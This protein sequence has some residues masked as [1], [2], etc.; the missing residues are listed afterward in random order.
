MFCTQAQQNNRPFIA[1]RVIGYN[2][3][4]SLDFIHCTV[5]SLLLDTFIAFHGIL[6]LFYFCSLI[7]RNRTEYSSVHTHKKNSKNISL[8]LYWLHAINKWMRLLHRF[9]PTMFLIRFTNLV[10]SR[11][12]NCRLLDSAQFFDRKSFMQNVSTK[13]ESQKKSSYNCFSLFFCYYHSHNV[14]SIVLREMIFF[15]EKK[16]TNFERWT[17]FIGNFLVQFVSNK[18]NISPNISTD[19]IFQVKEF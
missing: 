19:G 11:P 13:I 1:I 18:Q 5:Y 16:K 7:H 14:Y 2:A 9:R 12:S 3:R 17:N 15:V 4:P 6:F 8:F 10:F